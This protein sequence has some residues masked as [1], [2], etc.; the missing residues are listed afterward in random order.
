MEV[1]GNTINVKPLLINSGDSLSLSLLCDQEAS[2]VAVEARIAGISEVEPKKPIRPEDQAA[3]SLGSLEPIL[4]IGFLVV[5]FFGVA[6][7]F[8]GSCQVSPGGRE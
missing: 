7:L 8:R 6:F 1:T 4:L 5:A 2:D 3:A